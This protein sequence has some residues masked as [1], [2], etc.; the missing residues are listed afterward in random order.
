MSL[1]QAGVSKEVAQGVQE[2]AVHD[3]DVK[4]LHSLG[5]AQ[6]LSRRMSGFS[7]FAISFAII[8]I[9]AGGITAFGTGLSAA[10]GASIGIGW[11]VGA[12]SRLLWRWRW[13][14]LHRRTRPPAGCITGARSSAAA[15]GAGRPPGSTCWA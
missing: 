15:A 14:R 10:G 6:E 8:C 4:E 13:P 7:N 3:A 9:V 1:E 11:P 12:C 5:Y 2:G